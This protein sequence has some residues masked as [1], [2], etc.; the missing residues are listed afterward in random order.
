MSAPDTNLETQEK[1]HKPALMGIKG[2]V[3]FALALLL[4]LLAWLSYQG[5]T[6]QNADV[7]IDGRTGAEVVIE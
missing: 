4:G 6:P 2:V 5:Q 7:K 3:V 1:R